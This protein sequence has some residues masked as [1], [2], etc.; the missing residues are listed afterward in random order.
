MNQGWFPHIFRK[1]YGL[2]YLIIQ[3]HLSKK[4]IDMLLAG[5]LVKEII[6][7]CS[8]HYKIWTLHNMLLIAFKL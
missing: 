7:T 1:N 4:K 8:I 6:G 3:I 2:K 5:V